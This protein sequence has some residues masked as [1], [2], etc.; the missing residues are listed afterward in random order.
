M[1]SI[2]WNNA[3]WLTAGKTSGFHTL[4]K[5]IRMAN[6]HR[7]NRSEIIEKAVRNRLVS[8]FIRGGALQVQ[9]VEVCHKSRLR[10]DIIIK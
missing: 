10:N 9:T 4:L 3:D 6:L 1:L 8:L 2:P 7:A 5:Q